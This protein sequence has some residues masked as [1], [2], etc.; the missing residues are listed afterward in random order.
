VP[1]KEDLALVHGHKMYF[2]PGSECYLDMVSGTWEPGVTHLFES[3]LQPGMVVVDAGAHIGYFSLLAARRVG[4]TGKVFAFEPAPSNF[5]LL[6]KNIEINGYRNI[7]MPVRK[8]ILDKTGTTNLLL[9]PDSVGHSIHPETLGKG[10]TVVEVEATT[11]DDF[12]AAQRWPAVHLVK[13][14]IEGAEPAAFRGMTELLER[15]RTLYVIVEYI[16]LVL[17]RAGED[18]FEFLTEIRNLRLKIYFIGGGVE[19]KPLDDKLARR[20]DFHAELFCVR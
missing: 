16:P 1:S 13:M 10:E 17:R 6:V 12:F 18:P 9:R 14:D 20:A 4:P 15:N 8:A 7:I 2:G 11:L 5:G 3:L 19:L